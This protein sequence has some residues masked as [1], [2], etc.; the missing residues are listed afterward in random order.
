MAKAQ[1]GGTRPAD[2]SRACSPVG[3]RDIGAGRKDLERHGFD[4]MPS[5]D[6]LRPYG[7]AASPCRSSARPVPDSRGSL[8]ARARQRHGARTSMGYTMAPRARDDEAGEYGAPDPR[9]RV[10]RTLR[11]VRTARGVRE[12]RTHGE[13]LEMRMG[14]PCSAVFARSAIGPSLGLARAVPPAWGRCGTVAA[15]SQGPRA[16]NARHIAANGR[17]VSPMKICG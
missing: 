8:R 13:M 3:G 9:L 10:H 2:N 15:H 12:A 5:A 7:M 16:S 17:A 14:R 6:R 1:A 11:D 4:A